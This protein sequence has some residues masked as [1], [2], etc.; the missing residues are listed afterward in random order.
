MQPLKLVPFF[1]AHHEILMSLKVLVWISSLITYFWTIAI[2]SKTYTTGVTSKLMLLW[3]WPY[4]RA[5]ATPPKGQPELTTERGRDVVAG[6]DL[7]RQDSSDGRFW[8]D[9]SPLTQLKHA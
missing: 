7:Q 3:M 5:Q 8:Q 4:V 2:T 6:P 1:S 9:V